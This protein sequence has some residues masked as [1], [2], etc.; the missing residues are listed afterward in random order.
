VS[1]ETDAPIRV[2]LFTTYYPRHDRDHA[3]LFVADLVER[4]RTS[5][6][7]VEVIRPGIYNDYG[8]AYGLGV[9]KN[10]R[11]RPWRAPLMLASALR[12]VRRAAREAD[13]VHVYWL[14]AAPLGL[15]SGR[16]WVLTL[17]GSGTA[18]A[19]RDLVLLR[20]GSWLV[21]PV[22]RRARAVICVSRE[23]ER[24]VSAL[25]ANAVWIPN[26]VDVPSDVGSEAEPPEVLYAGRM[27]EEKGIRELAEAARGLNLVVAGDGPLRHLIPSAL[28]L[29]PHD[30]LEKLYRRAAVVVVPSYQEGLSV[31]CVEAMAFARP[32]VGTNIPG[33]AELVR[34]GETGRLVPPR[35]AAALR[36][37]LLELLEDE[38]LRRRMGAAA[39]ERVSAMCS[40]EKVVPA[41]ISVYR[42]ALARQGA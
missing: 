15:L 24:A 11:A 18:G 25:G 31:V 34:D 35:D 32:V 14:L 21:G 7:T 26:G 30:E 8:L 19:F 42:Q 33:V 22:L 41:T 5:G 6:V 39:R 2:A 16:P 10:V 1:G 4:L 29:V 37:A 17:Q 9:F 38:P 13:I 40:W 36:T 27:V 12:A 3:G 23:L 28:G 20:R